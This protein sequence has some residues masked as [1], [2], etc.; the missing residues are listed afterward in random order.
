MGTFLIKSEL[1]VCFVFCSSDRLL[2][3]VDDNHE[4]VTSVYHLYR[5]SELI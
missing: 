1:C 2:R 3:C 4:A 5:I